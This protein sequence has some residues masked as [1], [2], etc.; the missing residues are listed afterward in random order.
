M[1]A[2]EA[3]GLAGAEHADRPVQPLQFVAV[4]AAI[5]AA[6]ALGTS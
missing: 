4:E 5:H 1:F 2:G 6:T 3:G